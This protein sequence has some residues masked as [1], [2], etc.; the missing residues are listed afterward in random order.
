MSSNQDELYKK[1][2]AEGRYKEVLDMINNK[3]T[4]V[5]Q[6]IPDDN[7]DDDLLEFRGLYN[8][9][10]SCS[11]LSQIAGN[12]GF[13]NESVLN[14]TYNDRLTE[15]VDKTIIDEGF[16]LEIPSDKIDYDIG[17]ELQVLLEKAEINYNRLVNI[18]EISEMQNEEIYGQMY[19]LEARRKLFKYKDHI[20]PEISGTFKSE[21]FVNNFSGKIDLSSIKMSQEVESSK[22][23]VEDCFKKENFED[24][25]VHKVVK[26]KSDMKPKETKITKQ[27]LKGL[28]DKKGY[29]G[30]STKESKYKAIIII[31]E[32]V[33]N[34]VISG[35]IELPVT[36]LNNVAGINTCTQE[37]SLWNKL[38]NETN[39]IQKPIDYMKYN[40]H[41]ISLYDNTKKPSIELSTENILTILS[42][43]KKSDTV[44]DSIRELEIKCE[45]LNSIANLNSFPSLRRM[46]LA[47]NCFSS[48]DFFRGYTGIAN[49]IDLNLCQNK[50]NKIDFDVFKNLTGL[51]FLNLEINQI[52][53]IENLHLCKSLVSLNLSY[54]KID[55]I[56]NLDELVNLEKLY[57]TGNTIREIEGLSRNRK[58]KVLSI[59]KNKIKELGDIFAQIPFI[60]ELTLFDNKIRTLGSFSFAYLK[61]LYLNSNKIREFKIGYCPSMEELYLQNNK[62]LTFEGSLGTSC[63][64]L[65]KIDLSFNNIQGLSDV[66]TLLDQSTHIEAITFNNN[67]FHIALAK[68]TSLESLMSKI[69]PTLKKVDFQTVKGGKANSRIDLTDDHPA[70][71]FF[72]IFNQHNQIVT[73]FNSKFNVANFSNVEKFNLMNM[74]NHNY[75]VSKL[76][77][78]NTLAQMVG[79]KV[80]KIDTFSEQFRYKKYTYYFKNKLEFIKHS[81]V[82]YVKLYKH[83]KGASLLIQRHVRG[84]LYR[85]MFFGINPAYRYLKYIVKLR[86]LQ[87]FVKSN[88]YRVKFRR[89]IV[90]IQ[91][92]EEEDE[93]AD[94]DFFNNDGNIATEKHEVSGLESFI[95][96]VIPEVDKEEVLPMNNQPIPIST[97]S[98]NIEIKPNQSQA[99]DDSRLSSIKPDTSIKR[100]ESNK[101]SSSNS[102]KLL[103]ET[104][105][106]E[107]N[108]YRRKPG[109]E[110]FNIININGN[111]LKPVVL[112]QIKSPMVKTPV[113]PKATKPIDILPPVNLSTHIPKQ[114]ITTDVN[115]SSITTSKATSYVKASEYK[116]MNGRPIS[117]KKVERI[118]LLEEEARIE[119]K[120]TKEE[121]KFSNKELEDLMIKKIRKKYH[122]LIQKV[123]MN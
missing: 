100:K 30:L 41:F 5:V 107:R 103:K 44:Y 89:K 4:G 68:I 77:G 26:S 114:N 69:H 16:N 101:L 59:G 25:I 120:M 17:K 43:S 92:F 15:V 64:R 110:S 51:L 37:I 63:P 116:Y 85:K 23:C 40:T 93:R 102:I 88:L 24:V 42:G 84:C 109:P 56:E 121:N 2:I 3:D 32:D 79:N 21:S 74:L 119:I 115:E 53:K 71:R 65:K 106:R 91:L 19:Q 75:F 76:F 67:P 70:H 87:S 95:P 33:K 86:K 27:N 94:L 57:L 55:K 7:I 31:S 39:D 105:D 58:L 36:I 60:E 96:Q 48:L 1:L 47:S 6:M 104:I 45:N 81:L 111:S 13:P 46:D 14:L 62:I 90:Q 112:P 82:K 9:D 73:F 12:L 61:H 123:I 49:I 28:F 118:K 22:F 38:A 72:N 11:N 34:T 97:R 113:L 99:L 8:H 66:I 83:K 122:K 35:K 117:P 80:T 10:D 29:L 50:L 78:L 18:D 20:L 52:N 108:I 54:N 98:Q